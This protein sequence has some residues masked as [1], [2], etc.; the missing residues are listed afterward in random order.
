[1][2]QQFLPLKN[3]DIRMTL[4]NKRTHLDFIMTVMILSAIVT[5][6]HILL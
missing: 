3:L 5:N 2:N 1:M 4:I 6:D